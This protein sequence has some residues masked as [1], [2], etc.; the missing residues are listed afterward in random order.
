MKYNL[1]I[2]ASAA[3]AIA[4]CATSGVARAQ[5]AD[6]KTIVSIGGPPV[7]LN[8]SSQLNL[9]GIFMVGGSTSAT[10]V[11]HGTNNAVGV[12]QFG[13]TTSSSVGQAGVNNFTFVG[14]SGQS[15]GS[16]LSQFGSNNSGVIAQFGGVNVSHVVQGGP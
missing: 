11:Q 8:Q 1:L 9:A 10:V 2:S 16:L 7:A 3:A 6:I 5:S 15:T 14:Q 12:L 13:G 4:F